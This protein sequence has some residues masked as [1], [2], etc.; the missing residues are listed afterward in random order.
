MKMPILL[1]YLFFSAT[2]TY[3]QTV[4]DNF[5]TNGFAEAYDIKGKPFTARNMDDIEGTPMLNDSW[6]KGQVKFM[7]GPQLT[8]PE[9]QFNLFTNQLY[10]RKDN[11]VYFFG[12]PISEFKYQYHDEAGNELA[13]FRNGYPDNGGKTISTFYRVMADGNNLHLL[14]YSYKIVRENYVYN[15]SQKKIYAQMDE[16]Y[17][18]DVKKT[19]FIKL[20]MELKYLVKVLPEYADT[21]NKFAAEKKYNLRKE[22]EIAE[23]FGTLNK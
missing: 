7:S 1:S 20:K 18:Y 23:L 15:G 19:A 5:S 3:A 8:V 13:F 2:V 10:F 12:D 4:A 22:T 11:I 17:A 6:E 21:I 9:L 16:W 14:K